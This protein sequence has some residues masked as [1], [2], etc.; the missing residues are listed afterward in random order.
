MGMIHITFDPV[1]EPA[2]CH[3]EEKHGKGS[4]DRFQERMDYTINGLYMREKNL[5][6]VP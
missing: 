2:G 3:R 5:V 4:S 6:P 1:Q